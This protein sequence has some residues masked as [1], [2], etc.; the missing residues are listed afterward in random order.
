MSEHGSITVTREVQGFNRVSFRA[1]HENELVIT[2]GEQESLVITAPED[3]AHR[4]ET[5]VK[6]GRLKIRVTG[7]W[8]QKISD[9]LTT[10]FSRPKIRYELFVRSLEELEVHSI[11]RVKI[12]S[13]T[14]PRFEVELKGVGEISIDSLNTDSLDV[15]L[16][17]AGRIDI[18]GQATE[19]SVSLSGPGEYR[20]PDLRCTKLEVELERGGSRRPSGRSRTRRDHAGDRLDPVLR[21]AS[22]QAERHR[23]G[24]SQ[25]RGRQVDHQREQGRPRAT[26]GRR[27]RPG[28]D[29]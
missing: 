8:T 2:Q 26:R 13:L 15:E 9:A 7:G 14:T 28:V 1:E 5:E 17:G 4:V 22:D 3:I 21:I 6:D 29:D 12:P 23:S 24:R 16:E 20:A 25:P 19:A 27:S 11:S 18:A 10:T